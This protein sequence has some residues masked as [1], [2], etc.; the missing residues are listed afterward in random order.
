[1]TNLTP[2]IASAPT[3]DVPLGR[4]DTIATVVIDGQRY[5]ID[6]PRDD[7]DPDQRSPWLAAIYFPDGELV[8]YIEPGEPDGF[9]RETDVITAAMEWF[10]HACLLASGL[11]LPAE[12]DQPIRAVQV[13]PHRRQDFAALLGRPEAKGFRISSTIVMLTGPDGD[14]RLNM[15]ASMLRPR[16]PITGDVLL[17]GLEGTP[18]TSLSE[19]AMAELAELG[20]EPGRCALDVASALLADADTGA[21]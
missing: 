10:T 12:A 13:R 3:G 9:L 21:V 14:K 11:L 2:H 6:W 5:E 8:D 1:M 4:K 20:I 19:Q 17:L 15:L 7:E 16:G 18:L